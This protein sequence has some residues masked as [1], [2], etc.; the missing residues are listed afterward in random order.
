MK[1]KEHSMKPP[2]TTLNLAQMTYLAVN[3]HLVPADLEEV[4]FSHRERTNYT[5]ANIV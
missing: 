5:P 2:P 4:T 3:Q 1:T